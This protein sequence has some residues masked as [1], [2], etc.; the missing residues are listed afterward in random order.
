MTADE[1]LRII[2]PELDALMQAAAETDPPLTPEQRT[3][4]SA[5][6][7]ESD[8]QPVAEQQLRDDVA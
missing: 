8:T 1:A 5:V 3:V 7:A 4:L 6:L 2:G